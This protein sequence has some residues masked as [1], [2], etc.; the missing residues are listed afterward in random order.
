MQTIDPNA[1]PGKPETEQMRVI[2]RALGREFAT[3]PGQVERVAAGDTARSGLI[4]AHLTLVLGMLHEHHEAEDELLWPLLHQRVPLD[5]ELIDTMAE[6]HHGIAVAI[7]SVTAIE[8][9]WSGTADPTARDELASR[10]RQLEQILVAHLRLEEEAVLPLIHEHLTVPEW[11]AP[12]KH[13]MAHGPRRLSDKLLTAGIVLDGASP[14]EQAWF[15][16][17]MPPP[18]RLL[19]RLR[20]AKQYAAHRKAVGA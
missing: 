10:L 13:A 18:A 3:L 8:R 19:W 2:H 4:A 12:Q 15:L 6:Q 7:D 16:A 14:R 20:G 11:R 5:N 17:E 1:A 9:A